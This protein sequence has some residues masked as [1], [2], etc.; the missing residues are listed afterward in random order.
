MKAYKPQEIESVLCSKGFVKKEG[1]DHIWLILSV[2]EVK[3]D[4]RTKVSRSPKTE[5]GAELQAEMRKQLHLQ[6][7]KNKKLFEDL[8]ACPVSHEEY[9]KELRRIHVLTEA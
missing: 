5:Y 2:E 6:G 9:V 7:S 4:I 8:L 3:T 1:K